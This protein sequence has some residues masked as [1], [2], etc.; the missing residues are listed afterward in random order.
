MYQYRLQGW[1][2]GGALA[3]LLAG[4][5]LLMAHGDGSGHLMA[6]GAITAAGFMSVIAF[7][8]RSN[9]SARS[10]D[11]AVEEKPAAKVSNLFS[12][13]IVP[14]DDTVARA[15]QDPV[16]HQ[17]ARAFVKGY[18]NFPIALLRI[19]SD[20]RVTH[21]NKVARD[22]LGLER[23]ENP[24]FD[25]LVLGLGRSV[26]AWVETIRKSKK[27]SQPEMLETKRENATSMLQVSLIGDVT[28]PVG[29]LLATLSD[30]TQLQ[31]LQA[32]FVQSQKMQA[33]GQL[34]GGVAH[35][36]N[37]LLTAIS[38]YCDLL[39]IRHERGDPD[40]GDLVQISQN[41]NRAA[42]LVGQLLAFSRK[43]TLQPQVMRLNDALSELTH[44]LNR[45]VGEK[46]QLHTEYG[47]ELPD[48]FVDHRQLEQVIMNLVVNARDA[49]PAGGEVLVTSGK[50][51]LT[52]DKVIQKATVPAGTYVTI[53]VRDTG[54]GIRKD[55]M[56]KIFE[57][58]YSTKKVGE[59]TGLG[60]SMVYGIIKQ[61]GGFIFV[62]STE[63]QGTTFTIFLPEHDGS[64]VNVEPA[65]EVKT[66]GPKAL[67]GLSVML[68]E[69]EAP[70]RAFAARAL[71]MHGV[72]VTEASC[73]EVALEIL[74][75]PEHFVDIIV[76]DV[77]MPGMDGPTWV[78]K[79]LEQRPDVKVV[80]VSG[81]AEETFAREHAEN[82][83][84]IFLPKPFSLK[85]LIETVRELSR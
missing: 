5:I 57:P 73:A 2:L 64:V 49:M 12:H 30:A 33:I 71:K 76:S 41:S 18:E 40:Y 20:D 9:P 62:Q 65:K 63:G 72:D 66:G 52:E 22:Y 11:N 25:E 31:S 8:G 78:R 14:P 80:F 59:G 81:Y 51:V 1:M 27:N 38:G 58:F 50:R 75:D 79:A 7:F 29:T 34:A 44:L 6:G 60:L 39:L 43:Q 26:P 24:R 46:V 68:V 47:K 4:T 19:E 45:L 28:T 36:F 61:T 83:N 16:Q 42:A 55:Q 53:K 74:Q 48:I 84:A 13:N 37:N 17:T 35:D 15:K 56:Q 32:Q 77:V 54:C 3:S 69:D 82:P 10:S 23:G 70:V 85:Q 21:C 67:N